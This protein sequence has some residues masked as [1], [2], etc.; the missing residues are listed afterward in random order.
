[1]NGAYELGAAAPKI[2]KQKYEHM[3]R[4]AAAKLAAKLAARFRGRGAIDHNGQRKPAQEAVWARAK[5]GIDNMLKKKGVTVVGYNLVGVSDV[6]K[7]SWL[8]GCARRGSTTAGN[9]ISR[10]I[11]LARQGSPAGQAQLRAFQ[12]AKKLKHRKHRR[13][14]VRTRLQARRGAGHF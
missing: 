14:G 13:H 7:A 11:S 4:K 2:S 9:V 6:M 5:H 8:L 3:V 1:M 12:I 10:V